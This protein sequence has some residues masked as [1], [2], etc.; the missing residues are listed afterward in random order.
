[1]QNELPTEKIMK[2]KLEETKKVIESWDKFSERIKPFITENSE[3][4]KLFNYINSYFST[5]PISDL[6]LFT[7]INA[8]RIILANNML[9]SSFCISCMKNI[10]S[11]KNEKT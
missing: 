2:E 8:E 7:S 9:K 5:L 1:M 11:E 10:E 6:I 3:E 4:Q